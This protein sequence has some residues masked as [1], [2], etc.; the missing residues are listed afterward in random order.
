[1]TYPRSHLIDSASPCFYHIVSRCVRRSWLCGHDAV[2]GQSYEH[3]RIWIERRIVELARLFS[4]EVYAYA[5]MSNHYHLVLRLDP[6]ASKSWS[7]EDVISRWVDINPPTV[8]GRVDH[9]LRQLKI[10][11][12]LLDPHRISKARERLSNLSWFMRFLNHPIA[13]QANREDGC[14]GHFWESRFKSFALLDEEA[15]IA[16]MAYV[17]LNPIRTKE[18]RTL[19]ESDHTSIQRRLIAKEIHLK[20]LGSTRKLS[21]LSLNL[22]HYVDYLEQTGLIADSRSPPD[23]RVRT[24]VLYMGSYQWVYG[25]QRSITSWCNRVGQRWIHGLPLA[26]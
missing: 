12:F 17:D 3:R 9:V 24:H 19:L 13:C 2:T 25:T 20:P 15:I 4:L 14:T 22:D 21:R 1:M 10:D 26:Y 8:K 6:N 23:L 16:C 5:V 18:A 11:E 7:D